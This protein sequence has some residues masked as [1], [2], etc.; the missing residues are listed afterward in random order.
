MR[1]VGDKSTLHDQLGVLHVRLQLA[2]S[3]IGAC[4]FRKNWG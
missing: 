3:I 1:L 2:P 4:R